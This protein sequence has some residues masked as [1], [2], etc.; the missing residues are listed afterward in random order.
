MWRPFWTTSPWVRAFHH[1]R[2][3]TS[4]AT[5]EIEQACR[6]LSKLT[7]PQSMLGGPSP[8]R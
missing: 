6:N 4:D 8:T 2:H 5:E 7:L 1:Q 3:I